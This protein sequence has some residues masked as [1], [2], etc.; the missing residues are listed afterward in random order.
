M[1]QRRKQGA[2]PMFSQTPGGN[3][4]KGQYMHQLPKMSGSTMASWLWLVLSLLFIVVGIR[5][6]ATPT[7]VHALDCDSEACTLSISSREHG[8]IQTRRFPRGHLKSA[9]AVRLRRGEIRDPKELRSK[10]RRKMAYSYAVTVQKHREG[11]AVEEIAMSSTSLGRKKPRERVEEIDAYIG[12]ETK[13]LDISEASGFDWKG[14]LVLLFSLV[15]V[16]FA[17]VFGQF[18]EPKPR[19]RPNSRRKM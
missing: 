10:A 18:A 3:L 4:G 9:R 13:E 16:L 19:R 11:E 8:A 15:S 5:M 12:S 17:A 2:L 14:I 1:F 7:D 6:I